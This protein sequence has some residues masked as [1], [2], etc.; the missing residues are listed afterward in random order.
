MPTKTRPSKTSVTE[1]LERCAEHLPSGAA[2]VIAR[3]I[4]D[5]AVEGSLVELVPAEH[6]ATRISVD[7]ESGSGVLS[8]AAGEATYYEIWLGMEPGGTETDWRSQLEQICSAVIAGRFQERL[9]LRGDRVVRSVGTLWSESGSAD[10]KTTWHNPLAAILRKEVRV[11]E[12][13]PYV[14]DS[15]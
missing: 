10:E 8:V 4:P 13:A 3:D 15:E 5:G 7:V 9:W 12:Y 14:P 2:R 11:V 1:V 6:R